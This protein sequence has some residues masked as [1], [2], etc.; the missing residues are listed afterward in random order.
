[1]TVKPDKRLDLRDVLSRLGR[2]QHVYVTD[3]TGLF[4]IVSV[5]RRGAFTLANCHRTP[6]GYAEERQESAVT[7]SLAYAPVATG[8]ERTLT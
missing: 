3:G 5:A 8:E 4:E 7:L 6:G 2:G 1:M